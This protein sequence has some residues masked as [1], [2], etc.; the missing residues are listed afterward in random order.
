M[1]SMLSLCFSLLAIVNQ[2]QAAKCAGAGETTPIITAKGFSTY[3]L[4]KGLTQPRQ[5]VFDSVGNLLVSQK[6]PNGTVKDNGIVGLTLKEENGCLSVTS[7]S[8]VAPQPKIAVSLT[9]EYRRRANTNINLIG[10]LLM[11]P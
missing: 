5:L 7:K 8:M 11:S 6:V 10:R 2:A 4:T 1:S 3:L 9:I